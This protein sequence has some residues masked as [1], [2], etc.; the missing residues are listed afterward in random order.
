MLK[1]KRHVF[2]RS[3]CCL[4]SESKL[5]QAA[6]ALMLN[7]FFD[8]FITGCIIIN[9]LL[10]ASRDYSGSYIHDFESDWNDVID[11]IDLGLTFIYIIECCLKILGM[12]L[13]KHRN[14]YLRDAWNKL[15]FFIVTISLINF[16]PGMNQGYLKALRATRVLRPLRS[17]NAL[18]SIKILMKTIVASMTGLIN[19]CIFLS[20]VFGIFAILGLH[21]YSGK[22]YNF[23][24]LTDEIVDDGV[25]EPYWP[26]HPDAEWL[27]SND[28]MC[29]GHPNNLG[30]E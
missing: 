6:V 25:N 9:S 17:L 28:D 10:L 7:P 19:V 15:D 5:R 2:T 23:C 27:C 3:V 30:S 1:G 16:I 14:A 26:I 21:T 4:T 22:H 13:F 11:W 20:F 18:Q 8:Y 29:S 12:G 24:R